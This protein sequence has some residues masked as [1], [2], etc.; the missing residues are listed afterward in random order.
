M[1][2]NDRTNGTPAEY[3]ARRSKTVGEMFLKRVERDGDK[4]AFYF[5]GAGEWQPVG[6]NAFLE[7]AGAIASYLLGLG[8]QTQDK[9]CMVGSTS[10]AW[11]YCDRSH[12][13]P[14]RP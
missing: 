8:L 10:P 7:H 11:C 9:V 13:A 4:P 14:T 12:W 1:F 3:I 6:W 2:D 5:K